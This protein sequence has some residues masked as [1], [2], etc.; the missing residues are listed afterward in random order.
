MKKLFLNLGSLFQILFPIEFLQHFVNMRRYINTGYYKGYVKNIGKNSTFD[1]PCRVIGGIGIS[2][3]INV[4][5]AK[6]SIIT[7]WQTSEYQSPQII[8]GDDV[9]IGEDCHTTAINKIIIGNQVLMGKKIT[10]TDNSH[11]KNDS[12]TDLELPPSERRSYSKGPVIIKDRVWIGDKVTI[13]PGVII[14]EN[15]II[16]A[17][18]VVTKNVPA[19]TIVAGNP[20]K[21]IKIIN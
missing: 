14:E 8:F 9:S 7:V 18:S 3:G 4:S 13:L 6:G 21:I 20:A 19:N 2:L 15:A 1:Y 5:I 16:G 12:I 10:I 17:N 11:G